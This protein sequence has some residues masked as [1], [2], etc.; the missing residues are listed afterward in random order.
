MIDYYNYD[1]SPRKLEPDYEQEEERKVLESK[2]RKTRTRK[3]QQQHMKAEAARKNRKRIGY[4]A[5]GFI[6]LFA[7][8]YRYAL[9]NI[10]FEEKESL[11]SQLADIQKQN[12][13]LK[14]NIE[15]G[16]NINTIEQEAKERLG[17]QKIDNSQKVYINLDKSD[18]VESSATSGEKVQTETWWSKLLKDLFKIKE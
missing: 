17:M 3:Q 16:M 12:Q 5:V 2:P 18:Y 1:T 14:V 9:I 4:I 15:Q 11:K 7:I 6:I 8:S 10:Q 13:Q